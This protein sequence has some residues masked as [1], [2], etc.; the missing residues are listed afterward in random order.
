MLFSIL[1]VTLVILNLI[2]G[3]GMLIVFLLVYKFGRY[4]SRTVK[5][6]TYLPSVSLVVPTRNEE[7]IIEQRL[8]NIISMDY[9]RQLLEVLFVDDSDD[10][11]PEIVR[12]YGRMC[13]YIKLLKQEKP[14]FNNAMNQGYSASKGEIVIKS[15]CDAFPFK[16][17]LKNIVSNFA[18]QNIGAVS[19]VCY[20]DPSDR[21]MEKLFRSIQRR[22]K[23]TE[24]YFHSSLVFMGG[25]GAY[26]KH[27]IPK[28]GE[29][30]TADD[31]ELVISVVRKGYRAIVDPSV[32]VRFP[33]PEKFSERRKQLD[34]RAGGV[35]RILLK[36]MGMIFNPQY[37]RF[38]TL[39]MPLEFFMLIA[40]P[41]LLLV[42]FILVLVMAATSNV[43]SALAIIGVLMVF[44]ASSRFSILIRTF[45]D[46]YISCLHGI[47]ISFS[48][49]KTWVK[50]EEGRRELIN[51]VKSK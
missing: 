4:T 51:I 1:T 5:D 31:S 18:D 48:N 30:I 43:V 39:T 16:D 15:D 49:K 11:T 45:L 21:R 2:L 8:K 41:I 13:P 17:A 32:K 50:E 44:L 28:L 35:I 25:F 10:R 3:I 12:K 46:T 22:F 20:F 26:R 6:M 7:L 19:G 38:G 34:R 9:P 14:G 33:S 24:A 23:Q 40:V 42:D 29:E 47:L 27:L 36:N 37:G